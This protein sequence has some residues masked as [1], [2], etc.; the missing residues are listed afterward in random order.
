MEVEQGPR[1]KK[2]NPKVSREEKKLKRPP[3][4]SWRRRRSGMR[5]WPRR[6]TRQKENLGERRKAGLLL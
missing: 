3:F 4:C 6:G 5:Q 1:A 2:N